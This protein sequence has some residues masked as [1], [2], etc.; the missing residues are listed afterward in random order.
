MY[1]ERS[2][3]ELSTRC[4]AVDVKALVDSPKQFYYEKWPKYE[5][6]LVVGSLCQRWMYQTK[7]TILADDDDDSL[8]VLLKKV[9]P[10]KQLDGST[11][12]R[13]WMILFADFVQNSIDIQ[14]QE[15]VEINQ[16]VLWRLFL[17]REKI[18]SWVVWRVYNAFSRCYYFWTLFKIETLSK[19]KTFKV[20]TRCLSRFAL[21]IEMVCT[22]WKWLFQLAEYFLLGCYLYASSKVEDWQKSASLEIVCACCIQQFFWNVWVQV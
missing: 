8:L 10:S 16:A 17:E 2:F 6:L 5:C 1:R 7:N 9:T 22:F 4:T 3:Q 12:R 21:S 11:R 20:C 13:I 18:F 19:D 15:R 14:E